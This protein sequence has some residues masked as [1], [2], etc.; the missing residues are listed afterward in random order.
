MKDVSSVDCVGEELAFSA[1]LDDL[2]NGCYV[3]IVQ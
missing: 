2:I 1:E 3:M